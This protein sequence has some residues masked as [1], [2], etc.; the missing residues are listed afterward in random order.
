[1]ARSIAVALV[2]LMTTMVCTAQLTVTSPNGSEA[3]DVGQTVTLRWTG[4]AFPD[5][6]SID[7]STNAGT[8]W[9]QIV[10]NWQQTTYRWL[11]PNTP[12]TQCLLR[13]TGPVRIINGGTVQL[14]DASRPS[15]ISHNSIDLTGDASRAVVADED[16]YVMLFD[17]VTGALQSKQ[18]IQQ[19]IAAGARVI[20]AVFSSDESWVAALTEE[21]T[22]F[23]LRVPDLAV[24]DH[25]ATRIGKRVPLEDRWIATQ[26][27]GTR[28]AVSSF[29]HSRTYERN[30]TIVAELTRLSSSSNT[31][32]DWTPDGTEVVVS[33]GTEGHYRANATTG[34]MITTYISPS[35]YGFVS[36]NG[37]YLASQAKNSQAVL[38]RDLTSGATVGSVPSAPGLFPF[39]I[40]WYPD[41]TIVRNAGSSGGRLERFN[42]DGTI[43]DTITSQ[44][45]GFGSTCFN[46][47]GSVIGGAS[48]GFSVVIRKGSTT[49]AEQDVSNAVWEIRAAVVSDTATL[50]LDS[51][52]T[53]T[54]RDVQVPLRLAPSNATIL[55]GLTT[56]DVDVAWNAT[57]AEVKG[58]AAAGTIVNG[59]RLVT[60][61][62]PVV[63]V[64]ADVV[65]YLDLRTALG[66]DSATSLRIVDVR[67]SAD[68]TRIRRR[69]G[70]LTLTDLC[71]S[72][73]LRLMNG[74]GI[75]TMVAR[76][77][78][79]VLSAE[80]TSIENGEHDIVVV[81]VM[82]RIIAREHRDQEAGSCTSTFDLHSVASGLLF[83]ILKTPTMLITS[84]VQV[85]R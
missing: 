40:A 36:P 35:F 51:L 61:T 43:I 81:D 22:V 28:I 8:S 10:R 14:R 27:G 82:G 1:M 58:G 69:D 83:V 84:P 47:T 3:L 30:G 49:T 11:V 4:T 19:P 71:A 56:L 77:R 24:L 70:R 85:M 72:G 15:P 65:A 60:I 16:G 33:S 9:T 53:T 41:N 38:I 67:G 5:S 52:R 13:V 37:Q 44:P 59:T 73:G 55:A 25:W 68:P 74:D 42:V 39:G 2:L 80:W 62:V 20:R 26:P 46:S 6:V 7:Y 63:P 79:D 34:N 50:S 64:N 76:Q 32:I 17:A 45:F 12:S 48:G 78:D 66:N 31:C 23:I 54:L 21:D 57:L 18:R 29:T 75:A